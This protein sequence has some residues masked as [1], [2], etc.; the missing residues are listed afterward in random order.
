VRVVSHTWFMIVRQSRNLMREPIW[1]VLLLIQPMVWLILYG[2]LFKNVTCL[3]GFGTTSYITFLA[4]AIVIMNSFFGATW[5]GMAMVADI[6]RKFVE[7]FLATPV[8]RI[9]LV[10]SQI[11]RSALTAAIQAVII[12][13][14]ALAL[15][16]RVHTG[17]AGW[18]VVLV[19]AMLV[20]AAF[21]GFSQ[22]LALLTRRDATMITLA[23][24]IGL[25]L[26]FISTTLIARAQMPGWMQTAAAFNPVDWGVKASRAVVLPGTDWGSVAAHL[27]YLFA[28]CVVTAAFANWALGVYRRSL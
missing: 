13:V 5:S 21:A 11:I 19:V 12:L 24:F 17:I 23:N 3:G 20:N 14:V 25:P 15:G 28:L 8:A 18:I 10:L 26:L 16:V 7:R 9:A 6:D 4:P 2:Q 1:I 22:G 27:G